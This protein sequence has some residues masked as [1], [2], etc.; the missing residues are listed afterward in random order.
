MA[1]DER[2]DYFISYAGPDRPWAQWI[3]SVLESD[4]FAVE[5]D[6]WDWPPGS[7]WFKR[8]NVALRRAE[9][10]LAV[11][12]PRYFDPRSWAGT[13]GA[14]AM[15]RTHQQEGHLVPVVVERVADVDPTYSTLVK[16]E[17]T[18]LGEA[19]ARRQLLEPLRNETGRNRKHPYPGPATRPDAAPGETRVPRVRFPTARAQVWNVPPRNPDFTGRDR[20]LETLHTEL[21]SAQ[22]VVVQARHGTG[23]VGTSGLAIEYAHRF[24]GDY[25]VVWWVSAEWPADIADQL[26]TLGAEMGPGVESSGPVAPV[27]V[28]DELQRRDRWLLVFDNALEPDDLARYIPSE[29]TGHVL[30]TSRHV[31]WPSIPGR[32]EV[33]VLARPESVLLLRRLLG[34]ISEERARDLAD[35]LG[36]LP[37]EIARAAGPS[38]PRAHLSWAQIA[39][40]GQQWRVEAGP[41]GLVRREL[42]TERA[43]A[44]PVHDPERTVCVS[45]DGRVAAQLARDRLQVAWIDRITGELHDWPAEVALPA[46]LGP[47]RLL[48]IAV[49]GVREVHS[50][51]SNE[52]ATVQL[53]VSR[54]G[55][56]Q[57]RVVGEPSRSAVLLNGTLWSVDLDGRIRSPELRERL[58]VVEEVLLLDAAQSGKH[59]VIA[60]LGTDAE[61]RRVLVATTDGNARLHTIDDGAT[62]LVVVRELTRSAR[63]DCILAVNRTT[64]KWHCFNGRP[65]R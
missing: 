38:G 18:D 19:A 5:L 48:A 26:G 7:D 40:R 65:H 21:M 34:D 42:D 51:V 12:T 57:T 56:V 25:D 35:D 4:G 14:A 52:H 30:I 10:V 54:R 44:V 27:A 23:G 45:A 61:N 36:D 11:W 8:M 58:P 39:G 50:V 55:D 24:A 62:E 22:T 60:A 33:D 28:L 47:V 13:E 3:A 31:G 2:R 53:R 59:T 29:P 49:A 1:P 20:M 17:L 64:A 63:P 32:M 43:E 6:V 41:S 9:R 37:S 15:V 46:D 16:I